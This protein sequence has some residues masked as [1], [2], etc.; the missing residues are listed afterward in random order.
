MAIASTSRPRGAATKARILDA[1]DALFY[2]RGIRAV[3]VEDIIVRAD[4]TKMTLY[5]HFP[6]KD[7][8]AVEY[9][10]RRAEQERACVSSIVSERAA[11]RR[12][13]LVA[14]A[15]AIGAAASSEA[16]H[17]CP[18]L[19]AA[20]EFRDP[21]HPVRRVVS[22]H[23]AWYRT[24]LERL[25]HGATAS[26]PSRVAERV[27]LLRDGAMVGGYFGDPAGRA[28][29]LESAMRSILGPRR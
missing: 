25:A 8:L 12:G 7:A 27:M 6:S 2:E 1:A 11:D 22:A 5:R 23:R 13:A 4:T 24:T 14:L 17:G 15:G 26:D 18:F 20:G 29:E 9:L 10:D 21:E 28:A 3:S 19:S 16:F